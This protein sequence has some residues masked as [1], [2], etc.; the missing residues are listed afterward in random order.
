MIAALYGLWIFS[1]LS[2][3]K[4]LF[5]VKNSIDVD[6]IGIAALSLI[7]LSAVFIYPLKQRKILSLYIGLFLLHG[8]IMLFLG[9]NDQP[10]IAIICV[11]AF[12]ILYIT[13]QSIQQYATHR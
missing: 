3:G 9:Q 10:S 4:G 1:I 11:I 6:N 7:M 13:R 12:V 2:L 5:G 8:I